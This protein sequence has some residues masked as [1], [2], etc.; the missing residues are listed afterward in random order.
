MFI[1]SKIDYKKYVFISLILAALLF[2]VFQFL[3]FGGLTLTVFT[4]LYFAMVASIGTIIVAYM[5][6]SKLDEHQTMEDDDGYVLDTNLY[7]QMVEE[8]VTADLAYANKKVNAGDFISIYRSTDALEN[9]S[10]VYFGKIT[11]YNSTTGVITYVKSSEEEIESSMDLYIQPVLE[12]DDLVDDEAKKAIEEVVLK[13]VEDSGFAE[14]A[15]FM[16]AELA[17]RTDGFRNMDGVEV[18]L[19][20]ENVGSG[21]YPR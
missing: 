20:D 9:N 14:E 17:T 1:I 13:Q 8:G 6:S 16:L 15:G 4:P 10:E 19:S 18:L 5:I 7:K 2:V 12:G 21:A 3:L 11:A